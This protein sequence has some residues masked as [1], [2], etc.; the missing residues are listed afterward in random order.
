MG[1][2]LALTWSERLQMLQAQIE[3]E[4]DNPFVWHWRMEAKILRFLLRRHGEWRPES[5]PAPTLEEAAVEWGT[6]ASP[7]SVEVS[8]F[9]LSL[10]AS[11]A[12]GKHFRPGAGERKT[13]LK[14]IEQAN[15]LARA[16]EAAERQSLRERW[17]RAIEAGSYRAYLARQRRERQEEAE[18]AYRQ[19]QRELKRRTRHR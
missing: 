3:G 10:I 1:H 17:A 16:Q 8:I 18:R 5:V 15:D 19:R 12:G 2:E 13:V 11:Q 7:H 9:R 14:H 6:D 4:G